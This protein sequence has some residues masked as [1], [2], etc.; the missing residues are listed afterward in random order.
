MRILFV[1]L[2]LVM[3]VNMA[4]AEGWNPTLSS[5]SFGPER[6]IAVDK[7]GQELIMLERKSP[8][9]EVFRFPCTTG[10][11][12][13]DKFVEG[14]LRT[15]EGVYF[16]GHRINRKLDW[17]L[18]GDIAYS[19]N[20]PNP[21]DRINGKTGNGIWLHGRGKTFVPRDTRGCVALKVPDMENVAGESAYGTP[22]VIAR[23]LDWTQAPGESEATALILG[24]ELEAWA[25]DWQRRDESFFDHYNIDLM[26]ASEGTDFTHFVDR[27]RGIFSRLAWIQVMVGNVRAV[28]GPGYWVTWFDQYY[29]APGM[30]S[31]TGKRFYWQKDTSGKWRIVGR[32][33]VPASED[34]KDKYI[35][36]KNAEIRTLVMEWRTAWL[37]RDL[38][39]YGRF[40]TARAVQGNR[41]GVQAITNYKKRLWAT[42][43]PVKVDIDGV[44]V[45]Q[46][47]K[48]LEVAFRQ[49]FESEDGYSDIGRKTLVLTPDGN[50]WK[51]ESEQW[52]RGR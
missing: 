12:I 29:R 47:P 34:L 11:S 8:L 21:I 36:S 27:K 17:D 43:A 15:P 6:L 41:R 26:T 40:Y 42:K 45:T 19:L 51:I 49:I 32:E 20:Y 50:T 22:V 1:V 39:G 2:T 18:Y 52:R 9:H 46:H 28:P 44:I 23:D 38:D 30:A 31:T 24:R 37:A 25:T 10:Q 14:D 3:S 48:G 35:A 4:I 16:I 33:Y 13:G 7:Q 5:H